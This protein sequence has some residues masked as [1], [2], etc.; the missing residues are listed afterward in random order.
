MTMNDTTV[1]ILCTRTSE[2]RTAAVPTLVLA[3]RQVDLKVLP[4]VR[5]VTVL[6]VAVRALVPLVGSSA[7]PSTGL[8]VAVDPVLVTMV[9]VVLHALVAV[10]TNHVLRTVLANATRVDST[11]VQ[12]KVH[13][14]QGFASVRQR[15]A[16]VAVL[17]VDALGPT[18]VTAQT[19]L[20]VALLVGHTAPT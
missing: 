20:H 13:V 14:R 17:A 16:L 8:E 2:K 3:N 18:A 10:G 11:K 1:K 5:D 15:H 4:H 7:P 9:D 6:V 12:L 19:L